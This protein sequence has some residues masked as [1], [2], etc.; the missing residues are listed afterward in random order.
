[1]QNIEFKTGVIHPVECMKEGWEL[2]KDQYWLFFAITFVG[3]LIAGVVPFGILFGA[4]FCGIYYCLFQKMNGQRVTFEGLFK[5]FDYLVP[6]LVASLVLIVPAVILGIL[7]Y[8]PLIMMQLS[9]MHSKN[10]NPNE[11][12]AYLGFFT[13]EMI[14]LFLIL[15]SIHAFLFFAY[16]LIVEYKLSGMDAFKLSAKAVWNNL[17]GIAGFMALQAAL[18]IVGY[19]LCF[20]GVYLS[21]HTK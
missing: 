3:I 10:P 18:I 5:G 14:F 20:V 16:P 15:G 4:M 7:A 11:I 21:S 6:G 12:F 9:M 2:I 8:I 19:L 1:M 17:S 13:V